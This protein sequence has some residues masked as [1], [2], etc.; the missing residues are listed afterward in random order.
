MAALMAASL[1]ACG[2]AGPATAPAADTAK[3]ADA[4]RALED[5]ATA[6]ANGHQYDRFAALY[7]ADGVF[8]YGGAPAAKGPAAI[9]KSFA[10][11]ANDKAFNIKLTIDRVEVG[12]AGDIGYA[13]WRYEQASTDPKTHAVVHE[14]GNGIDTLRK[15]ADGGWKFVVSIQV[16]STAAALAVKP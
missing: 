10:S 16:P 7:A 4:I 8:I 15:G 1:G 5:Q 6:A 13:L 2:K 3:D 9:G 12:K 11:F 14:V